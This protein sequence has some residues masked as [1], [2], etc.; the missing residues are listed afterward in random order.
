MLKDRVLSTL[1][2]FD[3]QDF[4]LTLLELH[5]FL[6][7]D[8]D[9][10]KSQTDTQ[11]ELIDN[12]HNHNNNGN[13]ND[14]EKIGINEVAQCLDRECKEEVEQKNGFYCLR[15]RGFIIDLRLA[16]YLYGI[17]RERLI[18]RFA[19]GLKHV[20]FIRGVALAG[21]QAMG[22]Q[23]QD[24]DID[25]LIIVDHKFLWLARTGV[26]A[27][28]HILGLRRHGQKVANRFCLN[29]YLAGVKTIA[30]FNNLYTAWEYAK[31]R[32]LVYGQIIAQFQEK[33]HHW[34]AAF[35]PNFKPIKNGGHAPSRLQQ[36]LERILSGKFGEGLEIKLKNWQ[37]PK[38]RQGEFILVREDELS[39]HPHSKQ[40][41]LLQ[42]FFIS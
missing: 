24:S 21:S 38:I 11:W 14:N 23:K 34:L 40:Q 22:L 32:P 10:L 4:P 41:K 42:Q 15:G 6:L 35:F 30:E 16:N 18:R 5:N 2:F 31:L 7:A 12:N 8:V 36:L 28:F 20:P 17:K 19:K 39:F 27:Y 37:L 25:L 33:N 29:H 26:T 13:D 3:L 1:R 9:A